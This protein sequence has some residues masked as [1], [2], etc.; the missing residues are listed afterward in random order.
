MGPSGNHRGGKG[1]MRH[2]EIGEWTDFARNLLSKEERRSMA[3]HLQAGCGECAATLDFVR[4]VSATAQADISYQ[5]ASSLLAASARN[6]FS[7]QP[8]RGWDKVL[9]TLRSLAG[10]LTY[11]SAADLQPAGAR[12]AAASRQMLYE[13]GDF[14]LDLRFDREPDSLAVVLVGQVA[15]QKDP[16]FRVARLPV[17]ILAGQNVITQTT[18]NEFGE[19]SIEYVPKPNLRLCVPITDAGIRLEVPLKRLLVDHET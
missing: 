9:E 3:E 2:Y 11:D 18:S 6:I 12:G 10:R 13:A 16:D 4:R 1:L 8:D 15:N 19:F 7:H 14:F 17:L 5:S